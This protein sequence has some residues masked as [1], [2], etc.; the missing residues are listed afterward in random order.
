MSRFL[1]TLARRPI[2]AVVLAAGHRAGRVRL[3]VRRRLRPAAA[4]QQGQRRRRLQGHR[5][6]RRRPQRGAPH[7][8]S[9]ANDVIV[10]AGQRRR[11]GRLARPGHVPGAQ[12]HRPARTTSRSTYARPACWARSTSPWSSPPAGTAS[13]KRLSDGDFIPLSRTSR[14][15]EVEEVL[16]ALSMLLSGGGI[17]QL[18]TISHELNKMMNGRQD[19][20]RHAARQPRPTM[21]G[22]ARRAEE[23]HHRRDG[24]HRPALRDAGQGEGRH[25][26]GHRQHGPGAEGAQPP[27][28]GADRRC[29]ASSTSSARSAPG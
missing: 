12:G 9:M 1:R 24:L 5:R 4:R 25:R 23:R 17:G 13:A 27:A 3:Q 6:L 14:N 7:G 11:A 18:K 15:P 8:R 26:R 10:G 22:D 20:A 16:G 21:V 29:C 19:Q 28:P 2:A